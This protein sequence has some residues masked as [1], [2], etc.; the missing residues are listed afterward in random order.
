MTLHLPIAP[1]KLQNDT[2]I[3]KLG[4]SPSANAYRKA[5]NCL[6]EGRLSKALLNQIG[7]EYNCDVPLSFRSR[8]ISLLTEIVSHLAKDGR[9]SVAERDFLKEYVSLFGI[10]RED[11][12]S[13]VKSGCTVA[14]R[15]FGERVVN[16]PRITRG[17][18]EAVV[19]LGQ[20]FSLTTEDI[21]T[22]L[23]PFISRRVQLLFNEITNDGMISDSENEQL[24]SLCEAL[25]V[26][27]DAPTRS[28]IRIAHTRWE[29][30]AGRYMPTIS[31]V[32]INLR[33]NEE[34]VLAENGVWYETRRVRSSVGYAG[35]SG[36]IPIAKGL[37]MRYGQFGYQSPAS[38][39]WTMIAQGELFFT[40][41]RAIMVADSGTKTIAWK[42]VIRVERQSAHS[43]LLVKARGKSPLLDVTSDRNC[44]LFFVDVIVNRLVADAH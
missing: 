21:K 17:D 40:T 36:R 39:E 42:D 2:F 16:S 5:K 8:W 30:A 7:V 4:L 23:E 19:E 32:G 20:K 43:V 11:A 14:V 3:E 10:A 38:D 27:L 25:H 31:A 22:I 34:C 15:E 18:L 35:L 13:A 26:T 1:E 29:I 12:A 9:F 44:G 28:T 41:S 37:S 33:D 24:A 6:L